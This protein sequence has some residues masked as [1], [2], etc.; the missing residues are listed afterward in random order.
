V[1]INLQS[2]YQR[3]TQIKVI[4]SLEQLAAITVYGI[5]SGYQHYQ[6]VGIKELLDNYQKLLSSLG[7][8]V[9]LAGN[10]GIVTGVTAKGEL[11]VRLQSTGATTE[12]C[13][14]PGQISLGYR[15]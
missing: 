15:I 3:Q 4:T 1:G 9:T 11:R 14:P 2:Y 7:E 10:H 5:I 13:L 8:Q 6:T 12:V